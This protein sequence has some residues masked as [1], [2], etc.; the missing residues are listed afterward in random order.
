MGSRQR[1]FVVLLAA[2]SWSHQALADDP[3]A[4][5]ETNQRLDVAL[6]GPHQVQNVSLFAQIRR[7][8]VQDLLAQI[9]VNTKV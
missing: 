3:S 7:E 9:R 1:S 4:G 8:S 2:K 5:I 6:L